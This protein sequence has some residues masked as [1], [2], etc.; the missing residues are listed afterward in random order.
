ML[1]RSP[2]RSGAALPATL[3]ARLTRQFHDWEIWGRGWQAWNEPVELEPPFHPFFGHYDQVG[4]DRVRD[5]GRKPTFLSM[6]VGSLRTLIGGAHRRPAE[7]AVESPEQERQ[8]Y[9]FQ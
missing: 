8:P 7:P 6:I 5:D 2:S 1:D 9:L 3:E 4:A